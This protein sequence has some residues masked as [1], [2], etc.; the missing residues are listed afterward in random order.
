MRLNAGGRR[1]GA[2]TG[3]LSRG[4]APPCGA[5]SGAGGRGGRRAAGDRRDNG[6]RRMIGAHEQA[7]SGGDRQRNPSIRPRA[8]RRAAPVSRTA[9]CCPGQI[10]ARLRM[11]GGQEGSALLH[12]APA[13]RAPNRH[14][15]P[16]DEPRATSHEPQAAQP[17]PVRRPPAPNPCP[18][19]RPPPQKPHLAAPL[20]PAGDRG[21]GDGDRGRVLPTT[22]RPGLVGRRGRASPDAAWCL[23]QSDTA[24]ARTGGKAARACRGAFEASCGPGAMPAA[25]RVLLPRRHSTQAPAP[26][27]GQKPR[28]RAQSCRLPVGCRGGLRPRA[29]GARR[30][31][32]RQTGA[33]PA[34]GVR[35]ARQIQHWRRA[36]GGPTA[37]TPFFP[38]G[39]ASAGR[40]LS[41]CRETPAPAHLAADQIT[42][43]PCAG[44]LTLRPTLPLRCRERADIRPLCGGSRS[45]AGSAARSASP[46]SRRARVYLAARPLAEGGWR[47][48]CCL[49]AGPA[50]RMLSQNARRPRARHFACLA[51][52]S[53]PL[54]LLLLLLRPVGFRQAASGLARRH[55]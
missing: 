25:S 22:R 40:T 47:P 37:L 44:G 54:L 36:G 41:C 50:P 39:A 7:L 38:S 14:H 27:A 4:T 52:C 49:S 31:K 21:C 6:R 9:P 55:Q 17:Q 42:G 10:S 2:G 30:A 32:A 34:Q 35:H 33:P 5:I 20:V 15:A 28:A 16:I 8:R 43:T 24:Q 19:H 46:S 48:A 18:S 12:H 1:S 3:P 45:T 23:L 29:R 53:W 13:T 11:P 26:C 51:S